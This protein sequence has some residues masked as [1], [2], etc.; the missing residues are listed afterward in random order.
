M[1]EELI[2]NIKCDD[3]IYKKVLNKYI[4]CNKI[5]E[6]NKNAGFYTPFKKL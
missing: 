6:N 4:D 5:N 2:I 1:Q 3:D